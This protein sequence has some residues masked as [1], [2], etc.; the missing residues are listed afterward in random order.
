MVAM[1]VPET[2]HVKVVSCSGS[3]R[4][5]FSA[6][7]HSVV[8]A[9]E[10]KTLARMNQTRK[11]RAGHTLLV[12]LL[13]AQRMR[14]MSLAC[15]MSSPNTALHILTTSPTWIMSHCII[16]AGNASR[17]WAKTDY[18]GHEQRWISCS[19]PSACGMMHAAALVLVSAGLWRP[20][21][22]SCPA[23]AAVSSKGNRS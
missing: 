12:R 16:R 3:C 11:N 1:V 2:M 15:H 5:S 10:Y 4:F 6:A 14:R 7:M 20:R 18:V 9:T 23:V 8:A 22:I 19:S 17:C 13:M 21:V